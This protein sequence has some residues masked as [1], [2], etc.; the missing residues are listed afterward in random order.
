MAQARLK[1]DFDVS[2]SEL[3]KLINDYI[4]HPDDRYFAERYFIDHIPM[5]EIKEE[6]EDPKSMSYMIRHKKKIIKILKRH[7]DDM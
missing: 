7:F 4:H 3:Q 5:V 6:F 2:N 1:F